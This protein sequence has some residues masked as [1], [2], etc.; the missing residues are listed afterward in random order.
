[1]V[2]LYVEVLDGGALDESLVPE[3]ETAFAELGRMAGLD[4][5]E[6]RRGLGGKKKGKGGRPRNVL[7]NE[8]LLIADLPD[9]FKWQDVA[10]VWGISRGVAFRRINLLMEKDLVYASGSGSYR[11]IARRAQES[12]K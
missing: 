2:R 12:P 11:V 6:V 7:K 10:E 3:I 8:A 9:P 4:F 5:E 1:M